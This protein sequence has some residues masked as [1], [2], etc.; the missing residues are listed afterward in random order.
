MENQDTCLEHFL[1]ASPLS[2]G[3]LSA[4][5]EFVGEFLSV[6]LLS[7]LWKLELSGSILEGGGSEQKDLL[8]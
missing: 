1:I 3:V 5:S 7:L 8:Y 2:W 6:G 4:P